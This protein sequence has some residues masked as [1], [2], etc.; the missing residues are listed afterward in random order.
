VCRKLLVGEEKTMADLN[1]LN[2]LQISVRSKILEQIQNSLAGPGGLAAAT[3][4][5]KSDGTNYGMYTKSDPDLVNLW[6]TVINQRS[7]AANVPPPI[8]RQQGPTG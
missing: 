7:A 8:Q 3:Q 6:D 1:A 2:D 4:Y 5:T